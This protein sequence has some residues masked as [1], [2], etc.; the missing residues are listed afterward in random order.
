MNRIRWTPELVI[1]AIRRR[2]AEGKPLNTQ[3]VIA[4]GEERLCGAAR[5]Y[6]GSWQAALEAAGF[7]YKKIARPKGEK[8]PAGTWSRER[9][10]KL[11]RKRLEEGKDMAAGRVRAQDPKLYSAAVLYF[12]SWAKVVEA[13]G[14]DYEEVRLT[15][16]WTPEKV[17]ETLRQLYAAGEDI[18]DTYI[19]EHR[20]DLYGACETHFGGYR[21]AVE[22]AGLPYE[23]VRRTREW[24]RERL[25][26]YVKEL[27]KKGPVNSRTSNLSQNTLQDHGFNSWAELLEAAGLRP[28]EHLSYRAW[29]RARTLKRLKERMALGKPM[30]ATALKREDMALWNACNR[31][32][33]SPSQAFMELG[34]PVHPT[35]LRQIGTKRPRRKHKEGENCD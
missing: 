34:L 4:D 24:S 30:T 18:S 22:A 27:A 33:G 12:G 2:H 10:L 13:L 14:L 32:F 1:E 28:E 23:K 25:I 26:A 6:F 5:R 7:D 3:A 17:L 19:N 31:Y 29:N 11:A 20:G 15:Q 16:E 8:L 9:I 35:A 21:E